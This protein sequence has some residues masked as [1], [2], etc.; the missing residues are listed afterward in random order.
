MQNVRKL[1]REA[2]NKWNEYSEVQVMVRSATSNDPWGPES[3]LMSRIA[4]E[5]ESPANYHMMF[6]TLWKRVTDYQHL[7]HV[8]KALILV[9][10]LLKHG[11]E[12]F[13]SDVKLRSDVIRKLKHYKYF[14]D[15]RDIG[16]EVR[17]KALTIMTLLEDKDLLRKEREIA[18]RTEGKIVG[19]S[20]EYSNFYSKDEQR[21]R[22]GAMMDS[23][24]FGSIRDNPDY[25]DDRH[26]PMST[27]RGLPAP[28]YDEEPHDVERKSDD[29]EE[30][31]Q[32]ESVKPKK[33][34]GKK[35]KKSKKAKK[36]IRRATQSEDEEGVVEDRDEEVVVTRSD[37][38]TNQK[39][40]FAPSSEDEQPAQEE[41]ATA[42]DDDEFLRDMRNAPIVGG[43][44]DL[45]TGGM[46]PY[47][48][49]PVSTFSWINNA[50]QPRQDD[51]ALFDNMALVPVAQKKAEPKQAAQSARGEVDLFDF[52]VSSKPAEKPI[53]VEEPAK[54]KDPWDMAQEIVVLDNLN[55][56]PEER[57][58]QERKNARVQKEK[59]AP[60]LK[61]LTQQAKEETRLDAFDTMVVGNPT[62]P[63]GYGHQGHGPSSMAI[64]P[65]GYYDQQQQMMPYGHPY[66]QPY[67][68]GMPQYGQ[69]QYHW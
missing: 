30:P 40:Y 69:T 58:M 60:K 9:E 36:N 2:K 64:V 62:N 25:Y 48:A 22:D 38:K 18:R 37:K 26:S 57:R 21:A 42:E 8:L 51:F 61:N 59:V 16:T 45:I 52:G 47:A 5:S 7:K 39:D 35:G 67:G 28:Q 29:D 44:A 15:G 3:S 1:F 65:V 33:K 4:R 19:Y 32:D 20:Y 34:T 31:E 56:T 23:D 49:D 6:T 43:G 13:I 11:H 27:P 41:V 53:V 46:N 24:P 68:Y 66:A 12:R 14:K 63:T 17:N 55:M 50:P 10:Y 54:P